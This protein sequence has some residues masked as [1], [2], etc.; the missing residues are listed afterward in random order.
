MHVD[1]MTSLLDRRRFLACLSEPSRFQLV[2]TL[3]AGPRCVTEL[4]GLIG[5]S[6]SCTTRHLQ[7]L[8]RESIVVAERRGKRVVYALRP[9]RGATHPVLRWACEIDAELRAEEESTIEGQS[10]RRSRRPLGQPREPRRSG[11]G[12]EFEPDAVAP[13]VVR[14]PRR[15]RALPELETDSIP[16]AIAVEHEGGWVSA[17]AGSS[18]SEPDPESARPARGDEPPAEI[19]SHGPSRRAEIDDFLL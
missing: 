19:P 15:S 2:T 11:P 13:E 14:E 18:D 12:P 6:Q 16:R 3:S 8:L 4:A 10:S 17:D 1:A 5:L 7:A 9:E